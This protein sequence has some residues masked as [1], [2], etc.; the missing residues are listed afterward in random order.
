MVDEVFGA[1]A[2]HEHAGVHGDAVAAE[3]GPAE[4]VFEWFAG[5]AAVD[6][7]GEVVG[8]GRGFGE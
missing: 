7:G 3:L 2:W 1:A 4:D 6:Q 5:D 8:V